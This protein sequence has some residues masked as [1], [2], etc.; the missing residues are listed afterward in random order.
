MA[1]RDFLT[2]TL[3]R[4]AF[5]EHANG[6]IERFKR[7]NTPASLVLFDLDHFKSLNDTWGHAFGDEVL[8][9]TAETVTSLLRPS[10]L[11]GRYGGEEFALLLPAT[12]EQEALECAERIRASISN[13]EFSREARVTASF[14]ISTTTTQRDTLA[15][16]LGQ[17]DAALYLAKNAGRDCCRSASSLLQP[18]PMAIAI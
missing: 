2:G 5:T 11:I 17:A 15:S 10:D 7:H 4:R 3:T 16:L 1:R 18:V 12:D 9:Q 13:L 6:E 8:A 14:G